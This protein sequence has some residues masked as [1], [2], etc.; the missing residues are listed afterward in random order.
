MT[1]PLVSLI[2][3]TQRRPE[4]WD[5]PDTFDPSRFAPDRAAD[6]VGHLA[7]SPLEV[8]DRLHQAEFLGLSIDDRQKNHA[9][10]LLHLRVLEELVQHNLRFSP[11]L[12]FDD[13]AHAIAVAFIANVTDV[14]NGLGIN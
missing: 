2:I 1:P 4:A 12:E 13:D 3:P 5:S 11:A 6:P 8:F 10:R 7:V 9:E 14:F